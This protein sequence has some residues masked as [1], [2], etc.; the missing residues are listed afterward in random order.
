LRGNEFFCEIDDEYI[1]DDFNLSGL[2]SQV[3]YYDYALDLILDAEG[4]NGNVLFFG[5]LWSV[6]IVYRFPVCSFGKL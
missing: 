6:L 5:G 2:T 3:P 1:N 4:G